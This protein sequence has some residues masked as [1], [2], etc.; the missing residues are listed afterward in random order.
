MRQHLL[1]MGTQSTGPWS[2]WPLWRGLPTVSGT[3][4]RAGGAEQCKDILVSQH[5]PSNALSRICCPGRCWQVGT[6]LSSPSRTRFWHRPYRHVA[7]GARGDPAPPWL[8]SKAPCKGCPH[9]PASHFKQTLMG[10]V[11]DA[12]NP[13]TKPAM[14]WCG[15]QRRKR[16]EPG[17]EVQETHERAK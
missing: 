8:L 3:V 12:L 9:F 2:P 6:S 13:S 16:P 17:R 14:V 15:I 5:S 7:T 11:M 4:P 10:L 1:G